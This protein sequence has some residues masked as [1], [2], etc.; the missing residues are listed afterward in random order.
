[1]SNITI[2]FISTDQATG[3]LS[4]ETFDH[5][6]SEV[7]AKSFIVA[8]LESNKV[9]LELAGAWEPEKYEVKYFHDGVVVI[10]H[11]NSGYFGTYQIYGRFWAVK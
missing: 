1:M 11:S 6:G 7:T 8:W 3:E 2:R 10:E 5:P 9:D 4:D